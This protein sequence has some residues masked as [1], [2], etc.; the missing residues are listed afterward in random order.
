M[1]AT[2][3]DKDVRPL[4]ACWECEAET[5][6]LVTTSVGMLRRGALTVGLC[7]ECYRRSYLPL[8]KEAAAACA[9]DRPTPRVPAA[10]MR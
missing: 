7:A 1:L 9:N 6:E 4:S 8:L 5:G 10:V 2:Q 3:A